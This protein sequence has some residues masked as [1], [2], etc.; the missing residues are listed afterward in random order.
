MTKAALDKLTLVLGSSFAGRG[1]LIRVNSLQPGSIC[2]ADNEWQIF[3]DARD[4]DIAWVCGADTCQ[5]AWVVSKARY[6][7]GV[8][9]RFEVAVMLRRDDGG[10]LGSVGLYQRSGLEP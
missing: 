10:L 1:I 9:Y 2:V 5:E 8:E 3:G 7:N 6:L 4:E